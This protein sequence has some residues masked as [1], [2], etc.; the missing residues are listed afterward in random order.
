MMVFIPKLKIPL[1]V[2]PERRAR[3]F[4]GEVE[5]IINEG[6]RDYVLAVKQGLEVA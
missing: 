5:L 4:H 1:R 3:S 2:V 6:H